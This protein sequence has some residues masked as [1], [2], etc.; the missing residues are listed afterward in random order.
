MAKA[1]TMPT[2]RATF[3]ASFALAAIAWLS[4]NVCSTRPRASASAAPLR[5]ATSFVR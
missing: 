4:L 1:A 2:F 3:A 5:A